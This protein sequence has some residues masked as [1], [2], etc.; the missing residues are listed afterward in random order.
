MPA[1]NAMLSGAEDR[2]PQRRSMAPRGR[3]VFRSSAVLWPGP[4]SQ[5][6]D[7]VQFGVRTLATHQ[8]L[9]CTHI[10]Y[11]Y[12]DMYMDMDMDMD[13]LYTD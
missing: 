9:Q 13:I 2:A 5:S 10:M 12:M 6:A 1:G 4:G 7:A 3:P 8:Q 11:M